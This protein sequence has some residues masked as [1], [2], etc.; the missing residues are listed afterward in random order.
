MLN[1]VKLQF[2][3]II[4]LQTVYMP[5]KSNCRENFFFHFFHVRCVSNKRPENVIESFIFCII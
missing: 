4:D 2:C 3:I 1:Y 5:Q